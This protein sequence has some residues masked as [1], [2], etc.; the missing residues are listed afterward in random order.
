[1][2]NPGREIGAVLS[3]DARRR[4]PAVT[5]TECIAILGINTVMEL[6]VF[7]SFHSTNCQQKLSSTA[8]K[9]AMKILN[10]LPLIMLSLLP[11]SFS[12]FLQCTGMVQIYEASPDYSGVGGSYGFIGK[13]RFLT[14]IMSQTKETTLTYP[15]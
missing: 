11:T 10:L 2:T 8:K 12:L 7:R 4:W 14:S 5:P 15:L 6:F 9:S 1:M 3:D 13:V